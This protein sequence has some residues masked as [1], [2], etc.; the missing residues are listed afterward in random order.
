M[1]G[2][3]VIL[4][5]HAPAEPGARTPHTAEYWGPRRLCGLF[6]LVAH[7]PLLLE[8]LSLL[9]LRF[10]LPHCFVC[11]TRNT[12]GDTRRRTSEGRCACALSSFQIRSTG[13]RVVWS[14]GRVCA[15]F[16][17]LSYILK[18]GSCMHARHVGGRNTG[19]GGPPAAPARGLSVATAAIPIATTAALAVSQSMRDVAVSRWKW[20]T[21]HKGGG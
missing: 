15:E 9:V 17:N 8:L 20:T 10:T 12:S 7:L 5:Q 6:K 3:S 14:Y 2:V 18:V 4:A 11:E 21:G 16:D 13:N 1:A 19:G